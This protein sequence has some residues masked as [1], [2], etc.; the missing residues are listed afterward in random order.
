MRTGD[1]AADGAW[2]G[3]TAG[4]ISIGAIAA[5]LALSLIGFAAYAIASRG[6]SAAQPPSWRAGCDW[7]VLGGATGRVRV[8]VGFAVDNLTAILFVVVTAV[9]LAVQVY[10]LESMRDDP[11][12]GRF[13]AEI[14]L[15]CAA[16]LALLAAADL[17]LLFI[18]WELVGFCSYLLIGFW[19][20]RD[21]NARAA[22]KAFMV[23]RIG[24][25]GM[26]VALG[27]LWAHFGTVDFTR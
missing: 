9:A 25:V 13:F 8:S 23:N 15:F 24:D 2:S 1:R 18:A 22:Q 20:D 21:A 10:S 19:S 3:R 5:S 12:Q 6:F 14:S 16:M 26:L 11:R 4:L 27:I 7:A 17:L